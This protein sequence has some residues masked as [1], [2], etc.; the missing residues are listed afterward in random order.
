MTH[1]FRALLGAVCTI[2]MMLGCLSPAH[3]EK[4]VALVIG[5]SAYRNTVPLPNPRNDATDIAAALKGLGFETIFET[6]LD[7][8]GMDD[9][10]RRFA[11]AA[12]EADAALFYYAGH[13]MQFAGANY[14]MPV[15]AQLRDEADL[16]YEMAKLDDVLADL[17]RVKNI[18][19]VILDACR[20]NPL[21]DQLRSNLPASRSAAIS[22]GLARLEK[23]Q[24][25][26]TAF[27][28]Q[29]GQTAADGA[30]GT[31]NS[32]FSAAFL[33]H[34]ATP[35]LEAGQL[36]RRV[37][38]DVNEATGR[39]QLPELSISLLGEFYFAGLPKTGES[40]PDRDQGSRTSEA[41]R[42]WEVAKDTKDPVVLDFIIKRYGDT[43][44]G[45]LASA[46][47]R[48]LALVV[49][50]REPAFPCG[51]AQVA[52]IT[53]R[54]AQP[55]SAAEECALKPRDVFRECETCPEMVVIPT[56]EFVM[57]SAETEEGRRSDEGPRHHVRI[58]HPFAIGKIKISV[59]QFETFVQATGHPV[60]STCYGRNGDKWIE[61][62]GLSFRSPGFAQ[63]GAHPAVC[64]AWNDAKAYVAWLSRTTGKPYRLLTE[65]EW[66][67]AARAG[68]TTRYHFGNDERDACRYGNGADQTA[69]RSLP[70][71]W[72]YNSCSDGHVYT[73]PGGSFAANAFGLHDMLGD[74]WQWLEDCYHDNY[75]G[76]PADGSAWTHGDC[77]RRV[78]RG[79]SW[80]SGPKNLRSAVRYWVTPGQYSSDNG[81]RVARTLSP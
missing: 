24:G 1:P 54:A 23:A 43:I 78:L 52:T 71:S 4:P 46:R 79:G 53:L 12:R 26:I 67:Y 20:D 64:V 31:R 18:R 42:A 57:G 38:A 32:P 15:D 70:K 41:Q 65:A 81:F 7:K 59:D 13:G 17:S 63:T 39:K 60:G 76:A 61:L 80:G 69:R 22:R 29:S 58:P 55:L 68:S 11:R 6:D 28:T 75:E 37:A 51:G 14:L 36:F 25:M 8:R 47:K 45:A 2:L 49:P 44:Y 21:A 5:N 16:P 50:P 35:G 73:A 40:K 62:Q 72:V 19:L 34:V 33:R 9:A 74:A 3:A 30:A 66:E 48:E 56:G 10:F 77:N 27:A